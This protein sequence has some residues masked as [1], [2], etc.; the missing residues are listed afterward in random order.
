MK[1]ITSQNADGTPLNLYYE[2]WGSGNPVVFIHGWPLD[3]Q[4]WE[5]QMRVLPEM[6]LR[7]IAYDRRGFGKSDKPW[8]GYDYD[9]FADDLKAV[10]DQLELENVTLVGFSMGGGEVVR[11]FSRHGGA[12]VSKVILLASIVPYTLKT[13]DNPDGVP[14]EAFHEMISNIQEDRASFLSG[15]SKMFYGVN[16]ISHQVSQ[17]M[18]DWNLM[19]AMQASP[20]ATI[21]CVHA[22]G[23][24]DF[25]TEMHTVNVPTLIIHGDSDKIVPIEPTGEQ[26]ARLISGAKYIV[27]ED[28]PH[29]LFLT[30]REELN[31]DLLEFIS[32]KTPSAVL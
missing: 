21:D 18:L 5:H 15:F 30:N 9:T 24:T 14:L 29:G 32:E 17:A 13:E 12:R 4:M 31:Q 6:G 2:D 7:C 1:F 8:N 28:A 11:Y 16:L 25:R 23:E 3:H 20:K 10:L 26:A 22:F 19:L 27:Y